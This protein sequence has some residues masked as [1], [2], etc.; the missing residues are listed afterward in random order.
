[1]G[2]LPLQFKEGENATSLGL[3]G[4]EIF[5]IFGIN[6]VEPLSELSVIARRTNGEELKFKVITRLDTPIDIEYFQNGG[7]LQ[8][9]LRKMLNR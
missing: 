3:T 6:D 4:E 8:T 2:V 9:V 5:N 1:M 7:I